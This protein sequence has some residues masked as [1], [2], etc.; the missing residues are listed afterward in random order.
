MS[1][2]GAGDPPPEVAIAL[3]PS[4]TEPPKRPAGPVRH[5]S[6]RI[7]SLGRGRP[8]DPESYL[9]GK[10]PQI[11]LLVRVVDDVHGRFLSRRGTAVDAHIGGVQLLVRAELG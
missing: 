5:G 10:M 7:S 2:A 8:A 3:E 9:T 6:D 4:A 11:W 1:L